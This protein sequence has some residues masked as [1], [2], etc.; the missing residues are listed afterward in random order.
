MRKYLST[1][2]LWSASVDI[3]PSY[4]PADKT[5]FANVVSTDVVVVFML[6]ETIYVNIWMCILSSSR[7]R[8][9]IF[10]NHQVKNILKFLIFVIKDRGKEIGQNSHA[11]I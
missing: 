11:E 9:G 6:R 5:I 1:S 7:K 8:I 3:N 10:Y 4:D 2:A